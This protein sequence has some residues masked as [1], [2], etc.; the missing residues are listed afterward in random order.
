MIGNYLNKGKTTCKQFVKNVG[1]IL[2][3]YIAKIMLHFNM[4]Q[5]HFLPQIFSA[6]AQQLGCFGP[7][8]FGLALVTGVDRK[9][10]TLW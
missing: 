7:V 9:K 5:F 3:E 10:I 6:D 4:M 1:V 8:S 2:D